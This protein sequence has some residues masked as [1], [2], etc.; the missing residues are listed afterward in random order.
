MLTV[1]MLVCS[2]AAPHCD[3]RNALRSVAIGSAD[4]ALACGK[5]AMFAAAAAVHAGRFTIEPEREYRRFICVPAIADADR[6]HG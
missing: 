2:L 4:D 1:V 3:E 5:A 6:G